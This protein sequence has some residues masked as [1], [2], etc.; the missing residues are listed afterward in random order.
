[1]EASRAQPWHNGA[2]FTSGNKVHPNE[3]PACAIQP[4]I[5]TYSAPREIVLD[6]FADSEVAAVRV[7]IRQ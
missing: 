5:E 3:K 7:G 2:A 4:R 6:A 1:M